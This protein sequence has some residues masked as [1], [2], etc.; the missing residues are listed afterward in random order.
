[1]GSVMDRLG[2]SEFIERLHGRIFL[3]HFQAITALD[4]QLQQRAAA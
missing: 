1:M 2:R 3:T 4:P